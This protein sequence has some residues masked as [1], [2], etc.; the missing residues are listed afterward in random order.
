M[1]K[2]RILVIAHLLKNNKMAHSGDIVDGSAFVNLQES[3]DGRFCV[4]HEEEETKKKEA[5]K[6]PKI[7]DKEQAIKEVKKLDKASLLDYAKKK[8]YLIKEDANKKTALK[9]VIRQIENGPDS[10][11][12]EE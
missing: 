11:E 5:I 1:A 8:G 6:L 12:E 3:L 10:E 7:D 2:Y 4:L 9:E